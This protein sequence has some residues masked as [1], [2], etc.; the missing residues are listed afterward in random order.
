MLD[1][2]FA[3][4]DPVE[5]HNENIRKNYAHYSFLRWLGPAVVS[6]VQSAPAGVYYNTLVTVDKQVHQQQ[7]TIYNIIVYVHLYALTTQLLKYGVIST[8]DLVTDLLRW[9]WLY[10]SGR[11]HKPVLMLSS[12]T[13]IES[14]L[15]SNRSAAVVCAGLLLS[16]RG[17]T[18]EELFMKIASL[19]FM[20]QYHT[21]FS[22]VCFVN[23]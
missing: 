22:T 15:H 23:Q 16:R 21:V 12:T 10:I 1:L 8:A 6:R 20:G 9:R 19:S 18:M 14:A 3:V 17:F 4:R 13:E 11:L 7:L 5:W 2:V